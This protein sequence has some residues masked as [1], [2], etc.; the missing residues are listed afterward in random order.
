[1]SNQ[2]RVAFFAQ[3]A[4]DE[5]LNELLH[6]DVEFIELSNEEKRLTIEQLNGLLNHTF[7]LS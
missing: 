7:K 2:E 1:M 6:S 4:E 5:A 3:H